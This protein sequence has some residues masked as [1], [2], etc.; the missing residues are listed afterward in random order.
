V[1]YFGLWSCYD[2]NRK[3]DDKQFFRRFLCLSLSA[4]IRIFIIY[5]FVS[6]FALLLGTFT[7]FLIFPN[8]QW[9]PVINAILNAGFAIM[10]TFLFFA[11]MKKLISIAADNK[12]MSNAS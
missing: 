11:R 2:E 8:F 7:Y 4:V 1:I 10:I 12:I 5:I 9:W 6:A 3:G